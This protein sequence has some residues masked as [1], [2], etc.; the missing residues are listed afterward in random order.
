[1]RKGFKQRMSILLVAAMV[2]TMNTPVLASEDL[3]SPD[4]VLVQED[5]AALLTET[6]DSNLLAN[7][8][9]ED[10]D[11]DVVSVD[12]DAEIAKQDAGEEAPAA[13][14]APAEETA[15]EAAEEA[16]AEDTAE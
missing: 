15:E 2:F 7:D 13:E 1:M 3:L 16:P 14:E 10:E 8:E 5:S 6:E 12:I 11:A 4:E 9:A